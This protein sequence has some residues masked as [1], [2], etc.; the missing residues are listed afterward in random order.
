MNEKIWKHQPQRKS[1]ISIDID[2][3]IDSALGEN[4]VSCYFIDVIH[5]IDRLTCSFYRDPPVIINE[6]ND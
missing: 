5:N 6:I 2:L 1:I 3:L 4:L